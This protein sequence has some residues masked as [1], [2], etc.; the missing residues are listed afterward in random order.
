MYF[1]RV[2]PLPL[3]LPF[4][5]GYIPSSMSLS[6]SS[7]QNTFLLFCM[8]V[9]PGSQ[10][11]LSRSTFFMFM[12]PSPFSFFLSQNTPNTPVPVFSFCQSTSEYVSSNPLCS[13]TAGMMQESLS[14]S[15]LSPSSLGR[16]Q[17]SGN[18]SIPSACLFIMTLKSHAD[19]VLKSLSLPPLMY[20]QWRSFHHCSFSTV[21]LSRAVFPLLYFLRIEFARLSSSSPTA[22]FMAFIY[23][24]LFRRRSSAK[25]IERV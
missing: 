13:S 3:S 14:A 17:G 16:I 4:S 5:F 19:V 22:A 12:S 11:R 2:S 10:K 20:L 15:F 25:H 24:L 1:A 21:F 18:A 7:T 8:S 23:L 6:T 9:M